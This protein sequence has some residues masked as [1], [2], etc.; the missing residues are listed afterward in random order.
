MSFTDVFTPSVIRILVFIILYVILAIVVAFLVE[1]SLVG[2]LKG[3]KL[4]LKAE[5]TTDAGRLNFFSIFFLTVLALLFNLHAMVSDSLR[6]GQGEGG[7]HVLGP[8]VVLGI[9]FLGSVICVLLLERKK[10]S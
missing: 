5:F 6:V 3:L 10:S 2:A 8:L 9:V 7:D 1:R 4:A